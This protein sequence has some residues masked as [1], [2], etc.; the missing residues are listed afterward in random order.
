MIRSH[1]HNTKPPFPERKSPNPE[2]REKKIAEQHANSP[3]KNYEKRERS[4]RT[5]SKSVDKDVWLRNQ[6]TNAEEQMVCQIC[7]K[8]MPFKKRDG[9]YYFESV[10][11]LNRHH[12]SKEHEAQYVAL[13]P[14]CAAKFKEFIRNDKT[15]MLALKDSL[16]Q[17]DGCKV[18]LQL[19]KEQTSIR[20]VATH[21]QYIKTILRNEK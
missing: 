21:I 18:P 9:Y 10:E 2:R 7:K 15:A 1:N 6:Y 14:L 13:C 5:T 19:G 16:I 4:V 12:F 20:F 11:I 17:T 8:E 3:E